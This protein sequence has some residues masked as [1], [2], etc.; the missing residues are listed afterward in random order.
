MLLEP[1]AN[2]DASANQCRSD[3]NEPAVRHRMGASQKSTIMGTVH[4]VWRHFN[5]EK[6]ATEMHRQSSSKAHVSESGC[7]SPRMDAH[8]RFWGLDPFYASSKP[9]QQGWNPAE[10][11]R[12]IPSYPELGLE[13]ACVEDGRLCFEGLQEGL[14]FGQLPCWALLQR[15]RARWILQRACLGIRTCFCL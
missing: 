8:R 1:G 7:T 11:A 9:S 14:N 13:A 6:V 2:R 5:L 15:V 4:G 3:A 10:P 12:L